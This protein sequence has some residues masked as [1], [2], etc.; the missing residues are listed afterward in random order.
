MS[1]LHLKLELDVETHIRCI[2]CREET[3]HDATQ[4]IIRDMWGG[5]NL[6]R[7]V[8]CQKCETVYGHYW[9]AAIIRGSVPAKKRYDDKIPHE[10][11]GDVLDSIT[12]LEEIEQSYLS[13][14]LP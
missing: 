3:P 4:W 14:E 1:D 6:Y 8:Q 7:R 5:D 11:L 12:R 13:H 9:T 2:S 10:N